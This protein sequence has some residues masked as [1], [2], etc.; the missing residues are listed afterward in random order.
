MKIFINPGHNA[1]G[2]TGAVGIICGDAEALDVAQQLQLI[3][4]TLGHETKMTAPPTSGTVL[5]SLASRCR[6]SNGWGADLFVSIHFNDFDRRK[7]PMGTEVWATSTS[8][9]EYAA[10][11][12]AQLVNLNFKSRGVKQGAHL[13]VLKNTNATAVLIEICFVK[14]EADVANYRT[15]GAKE[16]A[17]AIAC[18]ITKRSIIDLRTTLAVNSS[19]ET[20]Q[21]TI[22]VQVATGES[23]PRRWKGEGQSID[24]SDGNCR[25]AKY[26][27]VLDVTKGDPDR[28]PELGSK[29]EKAILTLAR[30]LDKLREEWGKPIMV[31][32]WYRPKS[33]NASVGGVADSQHITGCAAD[34]Y[35]IDQEEVHDL[36]DWC[37]TRW[38]GALGYG[39]KK[40]F[41]HL[42]MRNG[43]GFR[44]DGEE[45]VRWDY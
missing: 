23:S 15:K 7:E 10:Q 24:W 27:K 13:F 6:Q 33:V 21:P 26:F 32:S 8:G 17:L 22:P 12:E 9:Y 38:M 19:R 3:L 43:K 39:A 14:S 1:P 20:S 45:G 37:D 28:V 18:G 42:D 31:S 11:I 25:I 40:G 5:E 44:S 35:P 36:Q 41:V 34:I 16:V 2:D 29:E 30:E 4:N